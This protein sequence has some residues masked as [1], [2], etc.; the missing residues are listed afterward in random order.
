MTNDEVFDA[1]RQTLESQGIKAA[2]QRHRELIQS[3]LV[4]AGMN[5]VIPLLGLFRARQLLNQYVIESN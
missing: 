3:Q 2:A 4:D 5:D 1:V